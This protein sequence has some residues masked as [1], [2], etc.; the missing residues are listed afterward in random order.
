MIQNFQKCALTSTHAWIDLPCVSSELSGVEGPANTIGL[1]RCP[2]GQCFCFWGDYTNVLCSQR[3]ESS[4]C[5]LIM[6]LTDS[7]S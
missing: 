3:C 5:K 7:W 1:C 4:N 6:L 2:G